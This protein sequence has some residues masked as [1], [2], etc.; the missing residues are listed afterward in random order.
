MARVPGI[1][2]LIA[3]LASL[4]GATVACA[5]GEEGGAEEARKFTRVPA[6]D[7]IQIRRYNA[8]E[9]AQPGKTDT[10]V[11]HYHGTL[12]NGTVFDSSVERGSP[13]SFPLNRVVPCWTEAV[14]RLRV[15]EKA[16]VTCPPETAYGARGAPPR[17]PPNAT[18]IFEI[19]LLGIR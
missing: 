14:S 10:V 2:C 1:M 15:G 16:E 12:Q 9:G 5:E 4:A 8:T 18:L 3:L 11:V 13:A 7:G 19:E 6:P 17:I